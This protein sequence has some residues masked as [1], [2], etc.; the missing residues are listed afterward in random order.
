MNVVPSQIA[1]DDSELEAL[2]RLFQCNFSPGR[3]SARRGAV[4]TAIGPGRVALVRGAQS[5]PGMVLFRQT[6]EMYYL[7]G[8]EV[9]HACLSIDGDTGVSTLYLANFDAGH[10][11]GAGDYLHASAPDVAGA[12]TGFD[13]VMPIEQ[14]ARD[15]ARWA[16]KPVPPTLMI[17]SRPAE[18]AATSR[19]SALFARAAAAADPWSSAVSAESHFATQLRSS[20][21]TLMV[22]DLSPVID[23]LREVKDDVEIRLLRRAG[24]LTAHAV[25]ESMRCTTPGV[26]EYQLAAVANFIFLAGGARGEGYRAIVGGG[27]NAWH[28]HYGRLSDPLVDGDLV[29]MDHAADFAYYTSDIGRMWPVNGS[30][31]PTQRM[32]YG[33]IVQYH[34]ELLSRIGPGVDCWELME[35]VR[36]VMTPV[37]DR[38]AW[39]SPQH[40]AAARGALQFTGH[41]SHPVGMCVHDVGDYRSRPLE[42]GVV[43]AIDPMI[44]IPE[45]LQYVRCED[46]VVV[47]A[48]G[49]EVLT[50]AAPLD[51]DEIEL[52]MRDGSLFDHWDPGAAIARLEL[53]TSS[54]ETR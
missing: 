6:N 5:D 41:M 39:D 45:E 50:S 18:G 46:T 19:D 34:R 8:V 14:L 13:R 42:P 49:C 29:L 22:E 51:C 1:G 16:L 38:T 25:T 33:F 26:T 12:L 53:A 52:A 35:E 21:P 10:A 48:D 17:P 40:E 2:P 37:V 9:A 23:R 44:W 20:F 36:E 3:L 7:T 43:M 15:V 54:G 27:K 30:F 47:T 4:A 11:R 28:G 31:T 32:L 24:M